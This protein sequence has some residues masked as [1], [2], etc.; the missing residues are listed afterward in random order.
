MLRQA[1]VELWTDTT[2][3]LQTFDVPVRAWGCSRKIRVLRDSNCRR[4]LTRKSAETST[5]WSECT[6][7]IFKLQY[8]IDKSIL[9]LKSL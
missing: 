7:A 5:F 9:F 1:D 3:K 6:D 8:T 4:S 2:V